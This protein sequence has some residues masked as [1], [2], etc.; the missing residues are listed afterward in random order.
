MV[1]G[2]VTLAGLCLLEI[3][4]AKIALGKSEIEDFNFEEF[5]NGES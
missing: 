3:I 2:I 1:T 5:F 4:L